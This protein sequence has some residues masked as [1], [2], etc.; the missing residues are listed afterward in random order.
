MTQYVVIFNGVEETEEQFFEMSEREVK[1]TSP[2]QKAIE[3]VQ[4]YMRDNNVTCP[5][6]DLKVWIVNLYKLVISKGKMERH[7]VQN[8]LSVS[9]PLARMTSEEYHKEMDEITS[10]LPKEFADWVSSLSYE[11]GHSAGYE[12]VLN[13]AREYTHSLLPVIESYKKRLEIDCFDHTKEF[14][15]T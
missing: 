11:H 13:Y 8:S 5:R 9:V 6:N 1:F 10:C 4:K 3:L 14:F 12:E 2:S 15:S 7:L